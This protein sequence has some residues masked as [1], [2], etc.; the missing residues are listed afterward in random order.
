MCVRTVLLKVKPAC[1]KIGIG[2]F[3]WYHARPV[4]GLSL[5]KPRRMAYSELGKCSPYLYVA[6]IS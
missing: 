4:L 2:Q 6:L 5:Q 1:A 3:I